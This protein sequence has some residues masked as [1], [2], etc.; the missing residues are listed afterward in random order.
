MRTKLLSSDTLRQWTRVSP[1]RTLAILAIDYVC[2]FATII[3]TLGLWRHHIEHGPHWLLTILAT[4]AAIILIGCLQHR[5]GLAGHEGA[6]YMLHPNRLVNDLLSNWLCFFPLFGELSQYRA[7]H[8][9]HH[10]YPN[11][12]HKDGNLTGDRAKRL[13][14][15]FPMPK[16]SFIWH[17][18][19]KFFWPPTILANLRDLFQVVT[20][21][22]GLSPIPDQIGKKDSPRISA[23]H[24]GIVYFVLWSLIQRWLRQ[25]PGSTLLITIT[26]VLAVALLICLKL[27]MNRFRDNGVKLVYGRRTTAAMRLVFLTLLPAFN[28]ML[29]IASGIN[30]AGCLI[31]LWICPLIYV[32]PYLMLLREIYQHGNADDG[33]IT[34]SRMIRTDPFTRWALLGY[35]NDAHIIHH[36]YPNIP[37]HHLMKVHDELMENSSDYRE[38]VR[39]THGIFT[40]DEE[41]RSLLD[42]LAQP[43][44]HIPSRTTGN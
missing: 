39:E 20:V 21:G 30:I 37:Y 40:G 2:V 33:E 42:S 44:V 14:A 9:S 12:P 16:P 24:M 43:G 10:L 32:F 29:T 31:I 17:Y 28:S 15:R 11:D 22:S 1:C 3:L 34:N 18:Y 13:Y 23:T 36:L 27:P 25:F 4:G 6:H 8:L 35:G 19:L 38:S 5:I 26:I 7:K 41:H